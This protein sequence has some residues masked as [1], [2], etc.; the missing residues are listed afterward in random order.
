MNALVDFNNVNLKY[1]AQKVLEDVNI[2]IAPG[3]IV[4]IVGPN[5]S[6]KSS[7]LRALI[8]ALKPASGQISRAMGLRIGYVPQKLHIDPTLP[9]TVKRFLSLPVKISDTDA[10]EAL[11]RAGV[12][13]LGS[14]QMSNLSG[15]QFQR[16]LLARA[17]L[18]KPQLLLL[19]EA[20]QGLDQPGSAAF[21]HHIEKV[22]DELNCAVL[23]IS[24]ELHV[25]MSASDRVICLNGHVCCEG[26]PDV[27]ASAPEY[28]ALFGSGTGGAL[29]LYR[30]DHDHV[31]GHECD[32]DHSHE[33]AE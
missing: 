21:Y 22:R 14:R 20:T 1:G 19:D 6:G 29:A 17:L 28:R 7:L 10:S 31:H 33:A 12:P 4:T 32:H 27:V 2:S 16:V 15:G 26:K 13:D 9:M 18:H 3:E 5:G 30:H 23:M 25:V 11:R 24:H 8:G